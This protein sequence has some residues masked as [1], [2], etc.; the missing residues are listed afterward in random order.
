MNDTLLRNWWLL[1][2]RGAI[3]IVFGVLAIAWPAVTLLTLA[4]LFAAFALLGGALW[5]FGAVKNRRDDRHWWMLM[6]FGL[7]SLAVGVLAT[8]NPAITLL[9][10]IL[11]MGANALVS[12]VLDIVIAIRVRKFIRGEWLLLLSGVASIVFGLIALLFPLGA[13]AVMLATIVGV[14]ALISGVL[15]LSLS[16]RVRAWSRINAGRSSPAAGTI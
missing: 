6:L 10:L 15:L 8:F 3:A 11:L 16:L 2:A 14:Y 5:I 4:A 1:A 13:G 12:G 7:V 9:T